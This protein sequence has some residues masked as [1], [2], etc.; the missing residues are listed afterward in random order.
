[1]N[2][3]RMK[4]SKEDYKMSENLSENSRAASSKCLVYICGLM[5]IQTTFAE[6]FL[7]K[8]F[9]DDPSVKESVVHVWVT[10]S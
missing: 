6:L 10:N 1:M 5:K 9:L 8:A 4:D 3:G 2:Q 7:N